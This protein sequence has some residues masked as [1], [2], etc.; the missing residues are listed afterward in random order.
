MPPTKPLPM[1]T[2]SQ[3][4]SILAELL[5]GCKITALESLERH[6]CNRLSARIFELKQQGF[7]VQSEMIK[8]GKKRVARYFI[9]QEPKPKQGADFV[10]GTPAFI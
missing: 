9:P 1:E 4:K 6:K 8:V 5:T 3:L 7:N 10:A 2:E